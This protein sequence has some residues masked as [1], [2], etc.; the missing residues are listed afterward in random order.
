[1]QNDPLWNLRY[2]L[3]GVGLALLLSVPIAALV[4]SALGDALGGTYGWRAGV[5][6]ALL[7]Y[8]VVGAFVLFAKVA[9]HET[10]PLSAQRVG[11]W[12]ASLWLWP[13]LLLLARKPHGPNGPN[14]LPGPPEQPD[15]ADSARPP[16]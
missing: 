16:G 15:Q 12:L 5:Y 13:G 9:R 1:M 10:R 8:V 7:L 2:A 14:G 11:L 6:S 4:G 3:A